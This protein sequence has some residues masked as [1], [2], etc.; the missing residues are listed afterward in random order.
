MRP[1]R[2]AILFLLLA[3][4]IGHRFAA[5]QGATQ[6][7]AAPP[8]AAIVGAAIEYLPPYGAD[9]ARRRVRFRIQTPAPPRCATDTGPIEYGFLIDADKNPAT[10][11]ADEALVT[12]G[13][14]ARVVMRCDARTGRFV[15]RL[16]P[17]SVSPGAVE[18]VTTVGQL[19]SADFF[20]APYGAAADHL[21]LLPTEP[22]HGRW[23][24]L[25]R[26]MP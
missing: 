6:P 1:T 7:G 16:G 9:I 21:V 4:G 15:S 20:W 13:I 11:V 10:G 2:F 12:L 18:L 25:E 8:P 5:A 14:D 19:P 23:A 24:I 26:V 17:V 3:G 22:R